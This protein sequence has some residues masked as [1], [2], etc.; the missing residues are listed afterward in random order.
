M[1]LIRHLLV[2]IALIVLC[3]P[4]VIFM[5]YTNVELDGSILKLWNLFQNQGILNT[6]W[7]VWGP[8]FLVQKQHGP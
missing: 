4:V 3:P 7:K 2:P 5:W 1:K 6:I 8:I